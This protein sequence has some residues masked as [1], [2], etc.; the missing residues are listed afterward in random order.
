[1]I[2]YLFIDPRIKNMWLMGSPWPVLIIAVAYLYFVLKFGPEF[3][4]FR[5][6]MNVDR[7]V[8]VYNAAQVLTSLYLVKEV[9]IIEL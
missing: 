1:M 9:S 4:K 7:L 6:P 5:S 8:M 2:F 3:M